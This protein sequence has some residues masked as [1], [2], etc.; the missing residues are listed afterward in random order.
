M[1][2]VGVQCPLAELERRERARPDRTHIGLSR[3]H[4]ESVHAHGVYDLEVDSSTTTPAAAAQLIIR[5]LEQDRPFT[6]FARLRA[7]GY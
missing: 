4:F 5:A 2:F 7:A 3:S 6:A 1:L